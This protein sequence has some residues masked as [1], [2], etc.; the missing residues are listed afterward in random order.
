M[1]KRNEGMK[2]AKRAECR[3]EDFAP[4]Q[5]RPFPGLDKTR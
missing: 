2:V 1:S 3:Y 4:G 5:F